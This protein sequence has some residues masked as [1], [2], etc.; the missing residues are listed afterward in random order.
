VAKPSLACEG[1]DAVTHKNK[2][3]KIMLKKYALDEFA[4]M[5]AITNLAGIEKY[6]VAMPDICVPRPDRHFKTAVSECENKDFASTSDKDFRLLLYQDGGL[7]L[8]QFE[9]EILPFLPE[10]DIHIFL[11]QIFLLLEGL[12]FFNKHDIVHHDIKSHNVVY[13]ME[14]NVIKFIDFGIIQR[15]SEMVINSKNNRNR[16]A[17]SHD[18]FPPETKYANQADYK[19]TRRSMPYNLFI[20]KLA[21]T[22][23]SYSLGQMMKKIIVQMMNN[24]NKIDV[25]CMNDLYIFFKKMGNR[26]IETRNY[27]VCKLA[28]EYKKIL[29]KY[30]IW[31]T[32]KIKL[33]AKSIALQHESRGIN[34]IAM[35]LTPKERSRLNIIV[36]PSSAKKCKEGYVRNKSGRCR[37]T[38][39]LVPCSDSKERNPLTNRCVVKCKPGY[40][41]DDK[42]KCRRSRKKTTKSLSRRLSVA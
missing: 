39:K 26:H 29:Q 24:K 2:I 14:T 5:K 23:D 4:E 16:M 9:K 19:L 34:H 1:D 7:S 30:K 32:D 18:V 6:I 36:S 3:S 35:D 28:D 10:M 37:K 41:R 38:R 27:D 8:H 17:V 11:T 33:S 12:C 21:Y 42:F 13:N 15:R 20:E 31:N 22:F 25:S 40:Q